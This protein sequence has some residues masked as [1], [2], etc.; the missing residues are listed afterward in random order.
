MVYW[1][2]EDPNTTFSHNVSQDMATTAEETVRI[3]LT[4][5]RPGTLYQWMVEARIW[6]AISAS[7]VSNFTTM[8]AGKTRQ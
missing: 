5:L 2:Y 4:D 3:I 7:V 1:D 8:P 6:T